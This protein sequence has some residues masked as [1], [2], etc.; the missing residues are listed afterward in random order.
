MK[1]VVRQIVFDLDRTLWRGTV[2]YH[3]R[4]MKP[5][6]IFPGTHE[7]LQTLAY[8]GGI[9]LHIASRSTQG[10]KCRRFL[11]QLFPDIP[12]HTL[13]IWPTTQ[14]T[15]KSHLQH[16]L[17]HSPGDFLMIDDEQKILDDVSRCYPSSRTIQ[18][19][20]DAS[21]DDLLFP[22]HRQLME[23]SWKG[24]HGASKPL[25]RLQGSLLPSNRLPHIT[26]QMQDHKGVVDPSGWTRYTS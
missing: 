13:C 19:H 16:I 21:W 11:Q 22:L 5:P 23:S 26:Q 17:Q 15:K 8:T 14:T 7:M 12:F 2:E 24:E 18:R 20:P 9:R 3:P 4:I 25:P 1:Q 10:S 6:P